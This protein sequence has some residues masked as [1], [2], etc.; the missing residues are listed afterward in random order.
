MHV[1]DVRACGACGVCGERLWG[2]VCGLCA[3]PW[4]EHVREWVMG[5]WTCRN[6]VVWA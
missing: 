4:A 6:E 3:F 2:A 1:C 5:V